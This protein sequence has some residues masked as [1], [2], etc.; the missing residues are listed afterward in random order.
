MVTNEFGTVNGHFM[1]PQGGL[2]GQM[3][4]NRKKYFRVEE[5]KRPKFEVLIEDVKESYR[6]GEKVKIKGNAKAY[7]GHVPGKGKSRGG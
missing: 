3:S 6:L 5:Y 4:L 1:A 7:A 2:L